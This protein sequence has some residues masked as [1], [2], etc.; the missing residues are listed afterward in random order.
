MKIIADYKHQ[1]PLPHLTLYIHGAPGIRVH[2]AVLQAYREDLR[3]VLL[4]MS[5]PI[6][7]SYY[8][9]LTAHFIDPE[10]PDL[11]NLIMALYTALDG[12]SLKKPG[13]LVDDSLIQG[14]HA[15]PNYQQTELPVR[16][17]K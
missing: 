10:T 2:R 4:R 14:L 17:A 6:P 12:K 9:E 16:Q 15:F 8:I 3:K 13:I 1:M 11:D 7:I 5:L